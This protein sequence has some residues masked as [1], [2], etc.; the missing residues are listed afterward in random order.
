MPVLP[1][2]Q[3]QEDVDRYRPGGY[4]PAH[5]GDRFLDG[6]YEIIHKLGY[7]SWST[8]WLARDNQ[9]RRYVSVKI[10]AV[11]ASKTS[12]EGRIL[13]ALNSEPAEHPGQKFVPRLLDEFT[14]DGVNGCHGCIVTEVYE[15]R[16][17]E[18]K[19]AG[20]SQMFPLVEARA[21][22]VQI[23]EGLDYIHSCGV[24]HGGK[25]RCLIPRLESCEGTYD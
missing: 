20:I 11:E 18:S 7:G 12:F 4:H 24:V 19:E 8:V 13:R 2:Y 3:W 16:V 10:V 14:I 5:I 9:E 21:I 23:R 22:A 17:A 6:C 15:C 25:S 1:I